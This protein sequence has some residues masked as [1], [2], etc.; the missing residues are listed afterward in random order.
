MLSGASVALSAAIVVLV[1]ADRRLSSALRTIFIALAIS[2]ASY[3]LLIARVGP[4]WGVGLRIVLAM[5]AAPGVVLLWAGV[6]MLFDDRF[7]LSASAVL[8]AVT[9]AFLPVT[10]L[11]WAPGRPVISVVIALISAVLCVHLLWLLVRGHQDD[12]DAYRRRLRLL[13]A[14]GGA[15]YALIAI[16][17]T[18]AFESGARH[19][20]VGTGLLAAQIILK[21]LWLVLT[22]GRPTPLE[23]L[24]RP[25]ALDRPVTRSIR[26]VEKDPIGAR[27]L[28][29]IVA[30]MEEHRAYRQTG[31]SIGSL[32]SQLR[33]PEHRVRALINHNLGFRNFNAFLNHYR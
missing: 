13:F 10:R 32:A 19:I 21:L 5:L 7:R 9:M 4:G 26:S 31:L 20:G 25:G 30:S 28:A 18:F 11:L 3:S 14:G 17:T 16:V 1:A 27:E 6:R 8:L 2:G 22:T 23:R 33:L 12:L 24:S 15:A 29:S